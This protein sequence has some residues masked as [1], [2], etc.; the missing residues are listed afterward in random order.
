MNKQYSDDSQHI[1]DDKTL[2]LSVSNPP[3][4]AS[5]VVIPVGDGAELPVET[6]AALEAALADLE[7]QDPKAELRALRHAVVE[8][9]KSDARRNGFKATAHKKKMRADYA[10][11]IKD[12]EGREV[13]PYLPAS[14][15]R[16]KDQNKAASKARRDNMTPD[17]KKAE[18]DAR[19]A[20]RERKKA[21]EKAAAEKA[22]AARAIV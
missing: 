21:E 22:M 11:M 12:T 13:R 19:S 7:P 6:L 5:D 20:R 17:Q 2:C 15:Q 14:P 16:R 4:Y 10:T 8:K 9:A 3:A 18:S 1:V